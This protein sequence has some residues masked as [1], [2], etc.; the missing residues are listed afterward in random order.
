MESVHLGEIKVIVPKVFED[1]RGFFMESYR[2]DLFTDLGIPY[3][4]V[5]DNH[6]RSVC[7]VVRGL[8]FQW[9]A[10]MAK[11]MRVTLGRVFLVAA[12]IRKGSPTL[13]Q[14]FGLEVS[15]ENKR[16][17]FAPPGFARG[18]CVLSDVAEL[19]YKCTALYNSKGEGGIRWNDPDIGVQWP[20][21]E[22]Q[23]SDKD[24]QAQSF[25]QWLASEQANVLAYRG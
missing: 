13:G 18:F 2:Q 3:N 20:A 24:A 9:D 4:F 19:Q 14:W 17:V 21:A 1:H 11:L 15:A 12:D 7:G 5:Q 10:P 22:A 25:A 6:S 8:H 23:V 16:Q